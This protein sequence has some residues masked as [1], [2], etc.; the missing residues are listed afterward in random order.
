MS[1]TAR[2]HF[3]LLPFLAIG[4]IAGTYAAMGMLCLSDALERTA[5]PPLAI[6]P[7]TQTV[8]GSW[9]VSQEPADLPGR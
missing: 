6:V 2:R 3:E 5:G 7:L 4:L 8:A 9:K 1:D